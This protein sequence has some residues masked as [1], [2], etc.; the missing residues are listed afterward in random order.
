MTAFGKRNEKK[1]SFFHRIERGGRH[2]FYF[3][4]RWLWS[5]RRIT[6]RV[7]AASKRVEATDRQ[8]V[9]KEVCAWHKGSPGTSTC[10]DPISRH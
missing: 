8:E 6:D 2:T 4:L 7:V 9:G 5:F 10:D 1:I 3:S